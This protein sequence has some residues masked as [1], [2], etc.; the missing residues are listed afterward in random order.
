MNSDYRIPEKTFLFKKKISEE[1]YHQIKAQAEKNRTEII[2]GS[3]Y[4]NVIFNNTCAEEVRNDVIGDAIPDLPYGRSRA[5]LTAVEAINPYAFYDQMKQYAAKTRYIGEFVV[6][7]GD[8][9]TTEDFW[10][11][12]MDDIRA[13]EN[14]RDVLLPEEKE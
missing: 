3:K 6:D 14:P 9:E 12:F 5:V 2:S 8:E 10:R 4:Y 11:K 7:K 13:G 1:A